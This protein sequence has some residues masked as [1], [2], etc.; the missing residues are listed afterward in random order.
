MESKRFRILL[1]KVENIFYIQERKW[2]WFF[3]WNDYWKT[4]VLRGLQEELDIECRAEFSSVRAAKEY[5]RKLKLKENAAQ[6]GDMI[7]CEL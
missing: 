7:I 6:F 4:H 1:D 5:I 3:G 2:R